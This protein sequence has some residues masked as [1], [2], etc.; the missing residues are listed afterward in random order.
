M[1]ILNLGS[2]EDDDLR[3]LTMI[4]ETDEPADWVDFYKQALSKKATRT[5]G[6]HK[7]DGEPIYGS[8]G[9]AYSVEPKMQGVIAAWLIQV[10]D[11]RRIPQRSHGR[12]LVSMVSIAQ[13]KT[14]QAP[15]TLSEGLATHQFNVFAQCCGQTNLLTA[16]Q[17]RLPTENAAIRVL[18]H[19]MRAVL[20][21]DIQVDP[22]S[23]SVCL[24]DLQRVFTS[25]LSRESKRKELAC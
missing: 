7:L 25:T 21:G 23:T 6:G 10:V 1:S 14:D 24:F 12:I 13:V 18:F 22:E 19:M 9:V 8:M 11:T 5:L 2:T 4:D 3:K 16:G 15:Q 20:I 17:I